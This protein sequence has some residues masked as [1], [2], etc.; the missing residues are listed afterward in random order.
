MEVLLDGKLMQAASPATV[1][2][3]ASEISDLQVA[4][5]KHHGAEQKLEVE[6]GGLSVEII[7][8]RARKF[9]SKEAQSKYRHLNVELGGDLPEGAKGVFAELSGVEP[10]SDATRAMLKV[11]A[12]HARNP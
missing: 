2:M 11:P 12:R 1:R 6:L 4:L 5:S 7:S 3:F 10:V 8:E 9:Q